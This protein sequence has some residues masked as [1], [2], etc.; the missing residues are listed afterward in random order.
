MSLGLDGRLIL[1]LLLL[2]SC[3]GFLAGLLGVGGG[4]LMVPFMTVILSHRGVE[5]GAAVKMAIATSMATILFTSLAS[6]RA[7]HRR[8]AVRWDIVRRMVPGIA[9]GGLISGAGVFAVIKGQALALLFAVVVAVSATQLLRGEAPIASRRMPGAWG[10]AAAGGGVG[11]VCGLVGAGGGFLSIPLMVWC[12]VA[13]HSAM[14]TSAALGFPIALANTAG[15][16]LAGWSLPQALP[17]AFGYIYLPA[18]F[19]LGLASIALAPLGARAA[20]ALGTLQLKRVFAAL[21]YS[22]AAYMLYKGVAG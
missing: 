1:E 20:H 4:M 3:T 16:V 5:S 8:G 22:L 21:L 13:I 15:Y 11:F 10:Q 6:L 19:A 14:G 17:G 12:N 18:L 7:H 2:G 9:L